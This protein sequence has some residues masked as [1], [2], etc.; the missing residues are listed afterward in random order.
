MVGMLANNVTLALLFVLAGA[1]L[2]Q[3]AMY[4]LANQP[5]LNRNVADLD[6]LFEDLLKH[7]IP[8]FCLFLSHLQDNKIKKR[9]SSGPCQ[10]W[11]R[12]VVRF[13]HP[14]LSGIPL[15]HLICLPA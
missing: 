5:K 1:M 8:H 6:S 15:A 9:A 7:V 13:A 3:C 4:L 10:F 12:S 11:L 2:H 14:E